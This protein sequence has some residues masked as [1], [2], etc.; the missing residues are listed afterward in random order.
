MISVV[1]TTVCGTL[2]GA[3]ADWCSHSVRRKE[4]CRTSLMVQWI[5]NPPA[6][7]TGS[8]CDLGS[9]HVP[10]LWTLHSR[11]HGPT[12]SKPVCCTYW[13]PRSLEAVLRNKPPQCETCAPQLDSSPYLLQLAKACTQLQRP[14]RAKNKWINNFKNCLKIHFC[15]L[16]HFGNTALRS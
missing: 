1:W 11:P 9:F 10:Q 2:Y 12:T 8:I 5:K 13:R 6:G 7:D 14:T 15:C 4:F 3:L 16:N